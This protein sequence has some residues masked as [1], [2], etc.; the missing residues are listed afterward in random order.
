MEGISF[1]NSNYRMQ[2]YLH[3]EFVNYTQIRLPVDKMQ[4]LILT[5]LYAADNIYTD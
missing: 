1:P 3:N 2:S 4:L 5:I